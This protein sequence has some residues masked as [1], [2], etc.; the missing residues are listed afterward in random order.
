[1]D[2][3]DYLSNSKEKRKALI[4]V[5]E[6][7]MNRASVESADEI[8]KGFSFSGPTP[9]K[10]QL[11]KVQVNE[12][13]KKIFNPDES[14]E[15]RLSTSWKKKKRYKNRITQV[16]SGNSEYLKRKMITIIP[17]DYLH[18][19]NVL[20]KP[21]DSSDQSKKSHRISLSDNPSDNTVATTK[22]SKP[23]HRNI[24]FLP[25]LSTV[26]SHEK[27]NKLYKYK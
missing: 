1:M 2:L 6:S 4:K 17:K 22:K 27:R 23:N 16:Y 10:F 18:N 20:A 21:I 14:E 9:K 13:L 7:Y 19:F 24:L 12:Q 5:A 8:D 26:E 3:T 15:N 25:I 11:F